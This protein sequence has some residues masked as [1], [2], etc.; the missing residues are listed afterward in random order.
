MNTYRRYSTLLLI[1]VPTIINFF[2]VFLVFMHFIVSHGYFNSEWLIFSFFLLVIFLILS[3]IGPF[4]IVFELRK[5]IDY[6]HN[7]TIGKADNRELTSRISEVQTLLDG[8]AQ[9]SDRLQEFH[10]NLQRTN[11]HLKARASAIIDVA[12]DAIV[13]VDAD[14][15]VHIWNV[16]AEKMFGIPA[17][18][19]VGTEF[20][21]FLPPEQ[22]ILHKQAVADF[23]AHQTEGNSV[24][25]QVIVK[26]I[27]GFGVRSDGVQFPVEVTVTQVSQNNLVAF[28]RD[29]TEPRKVEEERRTYIQRLEC[30]VA[31]RTQELMNLNRLL[32]ESS[33]ISA[34]AFD[35][36]S[37]TK[38]HG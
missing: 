20:T 4:Y 21:Q 33:R 37:Q 35:L 10:K 7:V 19:V 17:S 28:I 24:R 15:N 13:G 26:N 36:V 31:A 2:G 12:S 38:S 5:V 32:R 27:P 16:A 14:L 34:A 22:R 23:F 18:R 9:F 8:F 3:I 25:Y 11:R 1:A 30:D 6:F 29:M